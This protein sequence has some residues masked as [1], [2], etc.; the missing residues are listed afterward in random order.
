MISFC[1]DRGAFF[2]SRAIG[3]YG[4]PVRTGLR[5]TCL[6]HRSEERRAEAVHPDS[7]SVSGLVLYKCCAAIW[8]DYLSS[9]VFT[10]VG[11]AL[12][13]MM[14]VALMAIERMISL[15]LFRSKVETSSLGL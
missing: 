15:I 5:R 9:A 8:G 13:L 3:F 4:N 7:V 10:R 2:M 14:E 6:L 12:P 1:K 11:V